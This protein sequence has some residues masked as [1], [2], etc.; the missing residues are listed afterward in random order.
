ASSRTGRPRARAPRRPPA[1]RPW[2]A[3]AAQVSPGRAAPEPS[4]RLRFLDAAVRDAR[5]PAAQDHELG[6]TAPHRDLIL[7]DVHHLAHDTA[8][9]DDLIAPLQRRQQLLVLLRL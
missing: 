8:G 2:P 9:R 7:F 1:P 4:R 6:F 5:D 3:A